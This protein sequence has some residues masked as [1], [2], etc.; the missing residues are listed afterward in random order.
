MYYTYDAGGNRVRKVI[1]NGNITEERIYLG[2]Y[3]VYRKTVSSVLDT[4]R[5]T[6]HLSDDT[7]RIALTDTLTVDGGSTV[8]TPTTNVRYQLSNHL[9]S[10]SLELDD[11]AAIISYEEYHPFGSTAYR[12]GRNQAETS[13]KRYRYVGKERDEET[14]LYY[15]GARYYAAWLARFISVDPLKDK[16][17]Q[18]N[19]YNYSDN[20]PVGDLDIDGRQN[21]TSEVREGGQTHTVQAGDT[22]SKLAKKYGVSVD[23]LREL[24]KYEDTKIPIGADLKIFKE[25]QSSGDSNKSDSNSNSSYQPDLHSPPLDA[26]RVDSQDFDLPASTSSEKITLIPLKFLN[27]AGVGSAS[28]GLDRLAQDIVKRKET[29]EFI[30]NNP[31]TLPGGLEANR[32]L[33]NEGIES[34]TFYPNKGSGGSSIGVRNVKFTQTSTI[35]S[36]AKKLSH[37]GTILD[38]GLISYDLYQGDYKSATQGSV[39]LS[40]TLIMHP[41]IGP[42]VAISELS[43]AVHGDEF[44]SQSAEQAKNDYF[45]YKNLDY[46][47]A[48]RALDLYKKM[49]GR[50]CLN[51]MPK[52]LSIGPKN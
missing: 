5:E 16:Y 19:S 18:L 45:K 42:A 7:G 37:F 44:R 40:A 17:P 25:D 30:L 38:V 35:A 14:G 8:T 9:G 4:E 26:L 22:Y 13:L 1:E 33:I 39:V 21:T 36:A 23:Q 43:Y 24:N 15:Y 31:K 51:C 27:A 32:Q 11:T 52:N 28:Y 41:V 2:D 6:L 3:E 48:N 49:G 20:D 34:F 47:K 29:M 46:K 10:A 12:S 50:E